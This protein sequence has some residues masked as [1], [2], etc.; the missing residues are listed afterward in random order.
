MQQHLFLKMLLLDSIKADGL[1]LKRL[2]ML[3]R[4]SPFVNLSLENLIQNEMKKIGGGLLKIGGC[5]LHL[6]HNGFK[7]GN[8][9]YFIL[10]STYFYI[11]FSL[12][13]SSS[14][15][16]LQNKC[17]DIYSWFKQSP[18]RKQDLIDTID[19]FNCLME[20][21]I[22]VFYKYSMGFTW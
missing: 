19:D 6:T 12:G 18:A 10:I 5:P 9:R 15:W 1:E 2:L 17:I 22:L 3:G 16:N 14:D 21:T 13:L 20:K 8:H 7:A 11:Y 4:D